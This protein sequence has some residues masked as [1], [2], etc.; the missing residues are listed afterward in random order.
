MTAVIES[1]VSGSFVC[2]GT[3]A[4]NS[5]QFKILKRLFSVKRVLRRD[6]TRPYC[7]VGKGLWSRE[8]TGRVQEVKV[9]LHPEKDVSLAFVWNMIQLVQNERREIENS[10]IKD[11]RS[12]DSCESLALWYIPQNGKKMEL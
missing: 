8:Q 2:F 9:D 1:T 11:H 4:F 3:N 6:K 7:L 12:W 5:I 10:T